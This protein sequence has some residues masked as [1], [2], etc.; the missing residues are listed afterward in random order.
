[1]WSKF[2]STRLNNSEA[3]AFFYNKNPLKID[4]ASYTNIRWCSMFVKSPQMCGVNLEALGP[5][6]VKLL[7]FST[8]KIL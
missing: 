8:I 2:G 7:H 3:I 1:M 4:K 6:T 5:I